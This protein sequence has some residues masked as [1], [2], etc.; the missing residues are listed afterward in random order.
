MNLKSEYIIIN[1]INNV[2]NAKYEKD[3]DFSK[4]IKDWAFFVSV[5]MLIKLKREASNYT[6]LPIPITLMREVELEILG[7]AVFASDGLGDDTIYF[8]KI[9]K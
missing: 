7:C 1:R 8:G 6:G 3:P 4:Q 2:L 9:L 5:P